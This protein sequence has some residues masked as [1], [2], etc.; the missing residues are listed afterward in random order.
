[1]EEIPCV[2]MMANVNDS[3][4]YIGVT[5]NLPKRVMEHR[6]HLGPGFTSRYNLTKLIYYEPIEDILS[7]IEREKQLKRWS[8]AK[9]E[10]LIERQNPR[11]LDLSHEIGLDIENL[12]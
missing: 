3:V 4:I 6:L 5:G 8:R 2:Y 10:Q 9:K 7:A 1:M 11:W 12:K